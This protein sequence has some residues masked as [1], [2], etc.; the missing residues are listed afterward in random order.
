MHTKRFGGASVLVLAALALPMAANAQ[1]RIGHLADY[2]GGTS[3]I[4]K[5]FGEGVA[6]AFAYINTK[7]GVNG[8]KLEVETVDYGYQVPRALA[9]YKKWNTGSNKVA[10]IMGWG[11]ADTEALINFVTNDKIPY[12]SGS[13]AGALTDPEG[14]GDKTEKPAPYNFFYGPSYSDAARAMLQWAAEDWKKKGKT[15]APK[16]VH[17]GANHP[18][19]N[20]PKA[21]GEE[22]AKELGFEVLPAIQFAMAS[23]DFTAQ[24]LTLKQQG[25]NYAYLGN[26]AA[27]DLAVMKSCQAAGVDVQF[28]TN[29]W[30]V[31]ENGLKVAG[32]AGNGVVWPMRTDVVWNGSA[33]GMQIVKDVAKITDPAGKYR[34]LHYVAGVCASFY[35]KEALEWADKNGG[36]G[37]ENV[38]KAFYQKKDWVP[39]GLEGVCRP[40]TWTA[41]DHRPTTDVLIY[42]TT[43]AGDTSAPI[44]DLMSKG[45]IKVE[46]AA[47]I[48][49]GRKPEWMGW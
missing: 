27:S 34:S 20:A 11:T 13:Y 37:G 17:M 7:G 10:A 32:S 45:V 29:V 1:I 2:T 44:E 38:K 47:E 31:D 42:K 25:A 40:V 15:G 14:T 6:D 22:Y 5:P 21:A 12:L 49:L 43:V 26:T 33:P 3:D 19:P 39:A 30:G 36:L 41:T 8:K 23:G 24:C 35:M 9:T 46:K 28:M 18:Y 16:Y 48:K 4:G